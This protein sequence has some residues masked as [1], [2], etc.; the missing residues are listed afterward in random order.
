MITA[1]WVASQF[2]DLTEIAEYPH[3]G[4]KWVF[5]ATH[6]RDGPVVIKLIKPGANAERVQREILAVTQVGS[7]RIPAIF[8]QGSLH[9][10][11]GIGEAVW[12]REQRINGENV[13]QV[14]ARGPMSAT[15]VVRMGRN[16]LEALA[17]VA[18]ARI[19]H[20][21]VKPENIMRATDGTYWLLD[22]G[23]ARHLE[24]TS[25]TETAAL[26][27]PGTLG[28]APPEQFR[29]RKRDLDERT[30][31]FALAV[32]MVESLTGTHPYRD[33]ARDRSEVLRRIDQ[34][35]LPVPSIAW[36]PSGKLFDLLSAMG[37]QRIDCRPRRAAEALA[38]IN[39]VPMPASV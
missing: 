26:G 1:V 36:D 27:G 4:Q 38:W 7:S 9:S 6:P 18:Q 12:I 34:M 5:G 14:L 35:P 21:D 17:D 2:P 3:G 8:E 22:F 16:V 32:T 39:E 24:L 28:Y 11:A 20:R 13:R 30:D 15:E 33:G 19:V 37:Q 23:I 29:N 10:V 25:L 31:L